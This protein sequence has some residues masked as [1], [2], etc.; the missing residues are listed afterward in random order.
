[1]INKTNENPN[2]YAVKKSSDQHNSPPKTIQ[3]Q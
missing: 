2:Q 1:M 3:A